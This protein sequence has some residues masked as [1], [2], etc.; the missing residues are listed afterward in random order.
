MEV[1]VEESVVQVEMVL[2]QKCQDGICVVRVLQQLLK[3]N[4]DVG[5]GGGVVQWGVRIPRQ[6]MLGDER[7]RVGVE[8]IGFVQIKFSVLTARG[9]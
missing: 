8:N 1:G 6:D 4:D 5:G 3:Q 7:M 2:I 9:E